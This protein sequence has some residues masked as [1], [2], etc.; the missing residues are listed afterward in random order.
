MPART[1]PEDGDIV[2]Q[3]VMREGRVVYVLRTAPGA[4]Q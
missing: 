3:K 4:D 2:I 1:T